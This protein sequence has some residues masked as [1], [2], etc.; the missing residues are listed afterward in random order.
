[1]VASATG[2]RA[3]SEGSLR[4]LLR[5]GDDLHVISRDTAGHSGEHQAVSRFPRCT[6]LAEQLD[7]SLVSFL[8]VALPSVLASSHPC[9]MHGLWKIGCQL[10]SPTYDAFSDAEFNETCQLA[11]NLTSADS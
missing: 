5:P 4:A 7:L 10:V 9:S 2:V 1:L 8:A 3:R 6:P 11:V